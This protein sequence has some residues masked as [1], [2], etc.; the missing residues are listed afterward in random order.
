M[1][2]MSAARTNGW[3]HRS[4][5]D[6]FIAKPICE[7]W[8]LEEKKPTVSDGDLS[9]DRRRN[10]AKGGNGLSADGQNVDGTLSAADAR[11]LGGRA[12]N[13]WRNDGERSAL[14]INKTDR[15]RWNLHVYV[16]MRYGYT[17]IRKQ[18]TPYLHAD[19]DGQLRVT[20]PVSY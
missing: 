7:D 14:E 12:Q 2:T 1:R 17:N 4:R 9:L 18:R 3:K 19:A 8:Q 10:R 11:R 13:S 20:I 16:R 5:R 6:R 15:R